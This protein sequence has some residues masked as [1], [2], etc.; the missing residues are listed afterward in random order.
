MVGQI[1][2]SAGGQTGRPSS[3]KSSSNTEWKTTTHISG[4][5][6]YSNLLVVNEITQRSRWGLPEQ[7]YAESK[8]TAETRTDAGIQEGRYAGTASNE[9]SAVSIQGTAV[10]NITSANL[11]KRAIHVDISFSDGLCGEGSLSGGLYQRSFDLAGSLTSNNQV[12]GVQAWNI[13]TTCRWN[14]N[15]R[16]HCSYVLTRAGDLSETSR[17]S[18]EVVRSRDSRALRTVMLQ[19]RHSHC[20]TKR[21]PNYETIAGID[22][23]LVLAV[24]C[25]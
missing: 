10:L 25:I 18:F 7:K 1:R 14:E 19:P 5:G 4:L 11:Y 24:M 21:N 13:V 16:I 17:G 2:V 20:R 23:D 15:H 8:Q 22:F 12:C 9:T 3:A 6:V